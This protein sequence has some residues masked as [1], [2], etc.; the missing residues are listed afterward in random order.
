MQPLS[1]EI[2]G[3]LDSII[4]ELGSLGQRVLGFAQLP[5][6]PSAFPPDYVFNTADLNFPT[7][8]TTYF[9]L[10]I[11]TYLLHYRAD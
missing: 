4:S 10:F 3:D 6:D 5:L 7:V 2:R 1:T 9:L 8:C 11:C